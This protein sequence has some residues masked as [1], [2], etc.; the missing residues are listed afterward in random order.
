MTGEFRAPAQDPDPYWWKRASPRQLVYSLIYNAITSVNPPDDLWWPL[1]LRQEAADRVMAAIEGN[2]APEPEE[3]SA[4]TKAARADE[5]ERHRALVAD[6]LTAAKPGDDCS[7][8]LLAVRDTIEMLLARH[9][10]GDG[11]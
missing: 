11:A 7:L 3:I 8:E 10:L 6:L 1:S 9:G 2:P 4:E 5:L